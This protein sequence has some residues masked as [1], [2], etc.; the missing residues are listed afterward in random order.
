MRVTIVI[1]FIA[2]LFTTSGCVLTEKTVNKSDKNNTNQNT[3]LVNAPRD[4]DGDGLTDELEQ[5]IGTNPRLA[6]T[7]GDGLTDGEEVSTHSTDP[8]LADTDSG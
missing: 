1:F 6:D 7:D 8:L 3:P 5:V 2:T 4:T